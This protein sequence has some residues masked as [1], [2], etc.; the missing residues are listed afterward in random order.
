MIFYLNSA[1]F[2]KA[3][4]ARHG[5]K[6]GPGPNVKML[7][8]PHKSPVNEVVAIMID[9][10]KTKKSVENLIINS[11][12][13]PGRIM[14]G[15]GIGI[16]NVQLL[17]PLGEF[18]KPYDKGG[19][20]VTIDACLIASG[21]VRFHSEKENFANACSPSLQ[22]GQPNRNGFVGSQVCEQGTG[23]D[24]MWEMAKVLNTRVT[25]GINVQFGEEEGP[26]DSDFEGDFVSVLPNGNTQF[27]DQPYL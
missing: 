26:D 17:A 1:D 18:F 11:H 20:G 16:R 22:D 21:R 15:V 19:L 27:T 6:N 23:Y 13:L 3:F 14:L 7:T 25:A 24:F 8:V 4:F 12:G 5:D 10:I 9:M 2:P